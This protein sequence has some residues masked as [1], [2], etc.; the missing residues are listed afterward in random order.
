MK[1]LGFILVDY[2]TGFWEKYLVT[3]DWSQSMIQGVGMVT[4]ISE[5]FY[6]RKM[7]MN[8]T[9]S[10]VKGF[11]RVFSCLLPYFC[12]RCTL[13]GSAITGANWLYFL[14]FNVGRLLFLF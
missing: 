4:K 1:I 6:F 5:L 13:S 3:G 2:Q 10:S 7:A 8:N 9:K 14:V 11:F 12:F